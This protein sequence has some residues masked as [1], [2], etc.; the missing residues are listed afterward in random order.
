ML[1]IVIVILETWRIMDKESWRH[2]VEVLY[3]YQ[4]RGCI[5]RSWL[6]RLQHTSLLCTMFV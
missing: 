4:T 1:L 3:D 2:V 5:L 6:L